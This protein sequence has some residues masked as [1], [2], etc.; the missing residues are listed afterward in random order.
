M[1]VC[2]EAFPVS[3]EQSRGFSLLRFCDKVTDCYKLHAARFYDDL[4]GPM[5]YRL[6]EVLG[7]IW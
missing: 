2:S 1:A 7:F 4:T 6:R 3:V 5:F